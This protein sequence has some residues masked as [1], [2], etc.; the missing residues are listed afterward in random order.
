MKKSKECST[1][2]TEG[3]M[4]YFYFIFLAIFFAYRL[5]SIIDPLTYIIIK[6]HIYYLINWI[7]VNVLYIFIFAQ[8]FCATSGSFHSGVGVH[9]SGVCA[10]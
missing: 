1:S 3:F 8:Q 10:F 9:K 7:R 2:K 5:L 6:G 4:F